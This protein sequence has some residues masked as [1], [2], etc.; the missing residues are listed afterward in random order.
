M[1]DVSRL[2]RGLM[3]N[4][5]RRH[6]H[7]AEGNVEQGREDVDAQGVLAEEPDLPGAEPGSDLDDRAPPGGVDDD[8]RV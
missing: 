2:L 3:K 1:T 6:G 5:P 4:Q 7:V 8:L